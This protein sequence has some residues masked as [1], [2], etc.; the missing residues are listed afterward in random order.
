MPF[1]F[2]FSFS[3]P[4]L[5]NPFTAAQGPAVQRSRT[6]KQDASKAISRRIHPFP[7]SRC[8][9]PSPS[10]VPLSRK[11]G[12]VPSIPEPSQA[13]TS[14]ASIG[15]Y[16][17][18]PAKYKHMVHEAPERATEEMEMFAGAYQSSMVPSRFASDTRTRVVNTMW[19]RTSRPTCCPC[20]WALYSLFF[21]G[22]WVSFFLTFNF[23]FLLPTFV[24]AFLDRY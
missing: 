12:W 21:S 19:F 11:R 22:T 24:H 3:V 2:T 1:P 14:A 15:G 16:L 10:L 20:A 18:T 8:T 23:F 9:S 13:A 4:G 5:H 7:P 17:D 6:D